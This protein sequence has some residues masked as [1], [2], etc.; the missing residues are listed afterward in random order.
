MVII[1]YFCNL[2]PPLTGT[3]VKTTSSPTQEIL[4]E[5]VIETL[6]GKLGLTVMIIIFEVAGFPDE[7]DTFEVS[8]HV[9]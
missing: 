2:V 9:I 4:V 5:A 7:H 6:T 1:I 3:A 8:S